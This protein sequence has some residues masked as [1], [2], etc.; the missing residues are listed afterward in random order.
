MPYTVIEGL[1]IVITA[2]LRSRIA[3]LVVGVTIALL[4]RWWMDDFKD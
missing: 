1:S 4:L 3:V 2:P